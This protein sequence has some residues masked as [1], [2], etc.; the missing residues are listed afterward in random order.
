MIYHNKHCIKSFEFE[1]DS[2]SGVNFTT[3]ALIKKAEKLYS[4]ASGLNISRIQTMIQSLKIVM[5]SEIVEE[6]VT[7]GAVF[8]VL[9]SFMANIVKNSLNIMV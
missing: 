5:Y 2:K 4:L 7:I 3:H 9:L 6:L 8:G 1:L